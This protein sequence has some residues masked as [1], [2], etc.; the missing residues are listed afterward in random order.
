[1]GKKPE[2]EAAVTKRYPVR[3]TEETKRELQYLKL[4]LGAASIEELAGQLLA[5]AVR[6]K[7]AELNSQK[8]SQR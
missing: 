2:K 4:D 5:H 8:R 1:M 7:R 6:Q 3:M